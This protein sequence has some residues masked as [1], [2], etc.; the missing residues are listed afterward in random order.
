MQRITSL[1]GEFADDEAVYNKGCHIK[2][3]IVAA[4]AGCAIRSGGNSAGWVCETPRARV[5]PVSL[6]IISRA[7]WR[8]GHW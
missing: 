2:D 6:I 5:H 1:A 7:T 8:V 3:E 4:A